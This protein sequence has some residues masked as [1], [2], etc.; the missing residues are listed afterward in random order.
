MRQFETGK[1]LLARSPPIALVH[2]ACIK[3]NSE[4]G[5]VFWGRGRGGLARHSHPESAWTRRG[6]DKTRPGRSPPRHTTWGGE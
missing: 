6:Q 4:A 2:P 1:R 5:I 3:K